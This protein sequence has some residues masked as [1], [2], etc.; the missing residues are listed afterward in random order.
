MELSNFF[1]PINGD[2]LDLL[3]VATYYIIMVAFFCFVASFF[4]SWFTRTQV[5]PE[6]NTSRVLTAVICAVA[7]LSYFYIGKYYNAYLHDLRSI[8]DPSLRAEFR[9]K[10]FFAIGQM[11]YMDWLVTTPLLLIKMISILRP[12]YAAISKTVALIIIGDIFMV[13]T[14]FVGQQQLGANGEILVASHMIWGAISTLGYICVLIGMYRIY[15]MRNIAQP[16]EQ[17]AFKWMA[18]TIVTFWGVYPIGYIL[19]ALCPKLDT[20]I[21]N[22]AY[23]IADVINKAGIGIIAYMMAV[24]ILERRINEKSPE[25]AENLG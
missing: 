7:G 19:V 18:G 24:Q 1:M 22:I 13:I 25:V 17:K 5:A 14:G 15:Q 9:H 20:D 21:L 6:H 8:T 12:K 23:S 3:S 16:I 10:A 4:F 11:R 2:G